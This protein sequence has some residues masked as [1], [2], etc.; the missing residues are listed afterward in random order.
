MS[1]IRKIRIIEKTKGMDTKGAVDLLRYHRELQE[2][3]IR[4][5]GRQIEET[6]EVRDKINE[7]I[8]RREE[9]KEDE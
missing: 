1:N 4:R 8:K 5:L 9:N 6:A 2:T 3:K 7:E